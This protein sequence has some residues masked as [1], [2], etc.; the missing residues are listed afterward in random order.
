MKKTKLLAITA[1]LI[2]LGILIPQFMPSLRIPPASF[3][4]AAHV[5]VFIAMMIDPFA[6]I[7]VSVG[8][9]WGFMI[10]AGPVIAARA[11]SHIVFA[12]LGAYWLKKHR[13]TLKN[14]QTRWLFAFWISLIHATC[15]VL[16]VIPFYTTGQLAQGVY[17]SGFFQFV[18]CLIGLGG[19]VHSLVDFAIAYWVA[20]AVKVVE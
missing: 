10:S 2:A 4:L 14:K 7:A 13:N 20:K 6:A 8:V 12:T 16:V 19:L 1:L 15:E 17:N 3:T 5:P 9:A 11:L 18:I